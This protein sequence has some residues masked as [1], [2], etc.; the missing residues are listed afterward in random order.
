VMVRS[1]GYEA[2]VVFGYLA[3][4]PDAQSGEF[5]ITGRDVHAWA[6]VLFKE[7]GWVSFDPS[8]RNDRADAQPLPRPDPDPAGGPPSA[9]GGAG[10]ASQAGQVPG[11]LPHRSGGTDD[12]ENTEA[13][14]GDWPP[15]LV[16]LPVVVGAALLVV[17]AVPVA[18]TIRARRRRGNSDVSARIEGARQEMVDRLVDAGI[19]LVRSHTGKDLVAATE[20][21][22][23]S[24]LAEPVADL[25]AVHEAAVFA[26]GPARP[27]QSDKAWTLVTRVSRQLRAEIPWSRRVR[28]HLALT[29]F[30]RR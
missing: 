26:P 22:A 2:R 23:S 29:S 30:R 25:V 21:H 5:R 16:A 12:A 10:G 4:R 14:D 9:A 11:S 1:L 13:R 6:E 24:R 20:S 7:S 3:P 8:P 15:V 28:A 27:Q 18:K 19:P 17:G